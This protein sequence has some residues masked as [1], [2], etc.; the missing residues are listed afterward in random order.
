MLGNYRGKF[1]IF[2]LAII[3]QCPIF[4]DQ[5]IKWRRLEHWKLVIENFLKI[6]N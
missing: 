1:L 6:E 4:N 5:L 3:K 2:N